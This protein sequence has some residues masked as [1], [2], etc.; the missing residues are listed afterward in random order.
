MI[1]ARKLSLRSGL[2]AF[3]AIAA[4][5][6]AAAPGVAQTA[7]TP[8]PVANLHVH[9]F[10]AQ[11]PAPP[12]ASAA[13]A[14]PAA[15]VAP[16]V[17]WN[18]TGGP[19]F[20]FYTGSDGQAYA[21]PLTTPTSAAPQGGRLVGAPGAAFVPPGAI[22]G[23]TGSAI[24]FGRGVSNALYLNLA[25]GSWG[26]LGGTLT[27][28]PGVAAG[29]MGTSET[30]DVVVRGADG[31]AWL[32]HLTTS[33]ATWLNVGGRVL[34][35][36]GPAA[37]N[38]GGTLYVLVVGADT[39]VWVRSTTDASHWSHWVSLGGR[40]SGELGAATPS[41]GAGIV[42][43]RGAGN[44]LWYNEFAGTTTG[45]TPGWHSLGGRITSGVGGGSA[46]DGINP[47]WAVAL[48]TDGHIWA[49]SGVWPAHA[50]SRVL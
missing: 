6:V 13:V 44:A 39:A 12:N 1:S 41:A 42:Y 3:A 47:T 45:V 29:S 49:N 14:A 27:S 30:V 23:P 7:G 28:N 48:G 33:T 4:L 26:N 5:T 21:A 31:G 18:G 2:P 46:G 17:A 24:L 16:A 43:A 8:G 9:G 35:G 25:P 19:A 11:A 15:G 10:A 22:G 38:V 50:W 37:V 32:D 40:L 20:V 36:T 34:A